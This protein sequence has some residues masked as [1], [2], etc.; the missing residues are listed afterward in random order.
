MMGLEINVLKLRC[1]TVLGSHPLP[2]L[3]ALARSQAR[4]KG[5][6]LCPPAPLNPLNDRLSDFRLSG[7]AVLVHPDQQH[8]VRQQPEHE[9]AEAR[10]S[11]KVRDPAELRRT[12][13]RPETN[14][15]QTSRRGRG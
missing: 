5:H 6:H 1:C 4:A 7:D 15:G 3:P 8:G 14:G 11:A 12:Q 10:R 2:A 13:A 9:I